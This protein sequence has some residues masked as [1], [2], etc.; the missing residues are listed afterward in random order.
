MQRVTAEDSAQAAFKPTAGHFLGRRVTVL[1]TSGERGRQWTSGYK[2]QK[3]ERLLSL[4]RVGPGPGSGPSLTVFFVDL[5]Q[6]LVG[7]L[8][9]RKTILRL[10]RENH[11]VR[12]WPAATYCPSP[13]GYHPGTHESQLLE[14][15][16]SA[17]EDLEDTPHLISIFR[18]V[19]PQHLRLPLGPAPSLHCRGLIL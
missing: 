17:W 12:S 11:Q 7:L 1:Q 9:S 8:C 14:P 18:P 5:H 15:P 19:P 6:G 10:G 4:T 2:A 13:A 16:S 3:P